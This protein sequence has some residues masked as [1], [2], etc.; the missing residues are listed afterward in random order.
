MQQKFFCQM[1]SQNLIIQLKSLQ[2]IY[3]GY[4]TYISFTHIAIKNFY[5]SETVN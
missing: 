4:G 1:Y 2:I 3:V 5:T